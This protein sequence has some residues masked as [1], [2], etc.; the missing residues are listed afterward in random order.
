MNRTN[1]LLCDVSDYVWAHPE[2]RFEEYESMEKICEA[3]EQEGFA[4]EKNVGGIETAFVGT[5]G[6]GGPV[7]GFLGEYDAL[8]GLSQ[9]SGIT[10]K[11][12]IEPNANGHGCGHNLLGTASLAAAFALKDYLEKNNVSGTVK[13]FGCP[14]E[15]GGSGKTYMVREG[16]FKD[17]DLALTWHPGFANAVTV[18]SSLANYQ[19]YFKFEGISSHAAGSPHLGRSALDAVEL[20][21]KGVNYLRE[22]VIQDARMHYAVTNA[23]G[24]SPNVVQPVAEVLYLVRAPQLEQ[25]KSIFERVVKI[26]EGA[27]L[28]TET[29]MT[30]RF[31]K[32]CSN[33][34]PNRSLEKVVYEKM[35]EVGPSTYTDEEKAFAKDIWNTLTEEQKDAAIQAFDGIAE[36]G[37]VSDTYVADFITPYQPGEKVK[38]V[39][40]DVGDVSWVVPTAQCTTATWAIGT[41]GH[42]WQVVSQGTTSIAKKAMLQTGKILALTAIEVLEN[43]ELLEEIKQ[44]HEAKF[45]NRTYE[46]PIPKDVQPT[47]LKG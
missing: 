42:S 33:Y 21:N 20:M 38:P 25:V 29:K 2:T 43:K 44:E 32:A 10:E 5:Y 27:A 1:K 30:M 3:L 37:E 12:A 40:T 15:E 36:V 34:I 16:V 18:E 7:I 17:V 22:H 45:K 4:V 14:G 24:I 35:V 11:E 47:R 13:Y 26:A 39:S 23:G 8:A 9:K 28:M 6:N 46:C 41:P 31:D 19:V